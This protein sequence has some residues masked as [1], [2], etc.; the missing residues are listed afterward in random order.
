MSGVKM[1]ISVLK[2][3][4]KES[5]MEELNLLFHNNLRQILC[6]SKSAMPMIGDALRPVTKLS[7]VLTLEE[8][9]KLLQELQAE[10]QA[11]PFKAFGF[12]V[13][14]VE[15]WYNALDKYLDK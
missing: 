4:D 15:Q 14:T 7:L 2:T 10:K 1:L 6:V 9:D 3:I 13:F 12:H 8:R 11:F 5:I